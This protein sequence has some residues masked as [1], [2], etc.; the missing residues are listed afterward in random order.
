MLSLSLT[1]GRVKFPIA[2]CSGFQA[3]FNKRSKAL[4]CPYNKDNN[5]S[6]FS[7]SK[8]QQH[9]QTER[10][11]DTETEIDCPRCYDIMTLSYNFD[12]L[13]YFCEGC[14]LP[15]LIK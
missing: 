11:P 9:L 1:V 8:Q 10:E 2:A 4:L 5:K 15:F 13:H 7:M 3:S 6:L 12:R 14:N